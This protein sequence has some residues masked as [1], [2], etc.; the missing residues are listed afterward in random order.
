MDTLEIQSSA[1]LGKIQL[2]NPKIQSPKEFNPGNIYLIQETL[3]FQPG[4]KPVEIWTVGSIPIVNQILIFPKRV[5][6]P[7]SLLY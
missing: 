1:G 7:S 5:E 3:C 6:K 2:D 4:G